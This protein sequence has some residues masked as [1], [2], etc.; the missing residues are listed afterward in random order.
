MWW[1]IFFSFV[2]NLLVWSERSISPLERL[3]LP[4][5]PCLRFSKMY[6]VIIY[7]QRSEPKYLFACK[8]KKIKKLTLASHL[9]DVINP[10]LNLHFSS[11]SSMRDRAA[12][13]LKKSST[14]SISAASRE[15]K[16]FSKICWQILEQLV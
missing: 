3:G 12:I 9:F 16:Q 4:L 5:N 13:T 7:H 1:I 8:L 14:A 11:R 10:K 15:K 2:L 6:D